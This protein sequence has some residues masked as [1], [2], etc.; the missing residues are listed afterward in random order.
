MFASILIIVY[1][2]AHKPT[3]TVFMDDNEGVESRSGDSVLYENI[4]EVTVV[5]TMRQ[6]EAY[7]T[8]I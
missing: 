4:D 5:T 7:G 1:R 3:S 8:A 2:C 6:N